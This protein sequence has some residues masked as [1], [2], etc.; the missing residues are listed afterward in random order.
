[1]G[2]PSRE[3]TPILGARS[4]ATAGEVRI[5]GIR[6]NY[7]KCLLFSVVDTVARRG[8]TAQN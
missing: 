7:K 8:S 5:L 2:A 1:M 6:A 3:E 4:L